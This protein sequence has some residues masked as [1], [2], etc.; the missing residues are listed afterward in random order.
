MSDR[1]ASINV[2]IQFF[3]L[4]R[5]L[6]DPI[7]PVYG[8]YD[9]SW[10]DSD[11][12]CQIES[13]LIQIKASSPRPFRPPRHRSVCRAYA[14]FCARPCRPSESSTYSGCEV[15]WSFFACSGFHIFRS[16]STGEFP[17]LSYTAQE[18][19]IAR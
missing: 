19:D 14:R 10:R 15:F 16:K 5:D 1:H 8:T 6:A 4:Q 18:S 11:V 12:A 13:E 7:E 17:E 9:G 3:Y 2:S